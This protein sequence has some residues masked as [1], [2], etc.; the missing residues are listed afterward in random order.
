[1]RVRTL[2][3]PALLALAALQEAPPVLAANQVVALFTPAIVDGSD[4]QAHGEGS[5]ADRDVLASRLEQ[6]LKDRLQDRFDVRLAGSDG[7][8]TEGDFRKRRARALGAT[9]T[10]TGALTRIGRSVALDLTLAPVEE[11]GRGKAIVVTGT[12]AGTPQTGTPQSGTP[13]SGTKELPFIY[14]RLVIEGSAKLKTAF[15]GDDVI[16]EGATR[17]K[18]PRLAGTVGRSRSIA[19]DVISVAM[20]DTDRDGKVELVVAYGDSIAIYRVEGD[21][22]VEKSRIPDAGGGIVRVDAADLNRNGIAEIVAVRYRSGKA[23]SDIWEYDGK[24]YR[25]IASDLPYFLRTLDLGTEGIV[26]A[27]Q[28]TDPATIFRGPV[29]RVTVDR[30]GAAGVKGQGPPLPL[31]AGTWI[32]SFVPV[33][34]GGT[35]RYAVLGDDGRLSLLGEKGERLWEGMDSV[36]GTDLVLEP[37]LDSAQGSRSR[38]IPNRLLAIDL[39]GDKND[40]IIVLNNLVIPGGFFENI[41]VY[42]NAEALCY[43]QD[44]DR[45]DLAWR[46]PQIDGASRDSFVASRASRGPLRIGVATRDKG[47]MLGVFGEWRV[48]WLK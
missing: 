37:P 26:L 16:G 11:P 32:Y 8:K 19:G 44:G 35:T 28:E 43:A 46:T 6:A 45:L 38:A 23:V 25:R 48:L 22:L 36:S 14:R 30:Q 42:A 10:L 17:H 39:D 29:F 18:I 3:L 31:P 2:L 33:R 41:R 24:D 7:G 15:F 12:E 27:G 21:D 1:M 47:K 9:Y 34:S 13:Q 5:A 20:T 40:E 4:P